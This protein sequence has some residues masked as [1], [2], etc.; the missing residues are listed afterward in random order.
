MKI[1][2][3]LRKMGLETLIEEANRENWLIPT[4]D[5]LKGL[6]L[7]YDYVWIIDG[8]DLDAYTP[9]DIKYGVSLGYAFNTKTQKKE[10]VN[11]KFMLQCIVIKDAVKDFSVRD[12][13]NICFERAYKNALEN[14]DLDKETARKSANRYAVS[15]AWKEYNK[16]IKNE[17]TNSK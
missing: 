10:I 7:D 8:V 3:L 5:Q 6:K 9:E 2:H 17:N 15:N 13:Y 1:K 14:L 4:E 12:A 16:R 11:Q